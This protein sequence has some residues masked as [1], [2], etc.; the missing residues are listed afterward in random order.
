MFVPVLLLRHSPGYIRS[1][2]LFTHISYHSSAPRL[3]NMPMTASSWIPHCYPPTHRS[4]HID[5]YHSES[6]GEVKVP[7]PYAWLERDGEE[8]ERWLASQEALARKFLDSHPDRATLEEEIRSSTDYEKVRIFILWIQRNV[9]Y[10]CQSSSV[11]PHCGTM[12]D[13]T[14]HIIAAC[15]RNLV[16]HP[17]RGSILF[18][19][20]TETVY[21]R[22]KD[23][24][25]PEAVL[26]P[27][28]EVFFDVRSKALPKLYALHLVSA[29]CSV[30]RRLCFSEYIVL[31]A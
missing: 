4:D 20:F 13:G 31:L 15:S 28:G 12:V 27:G 25:L 16:C 9:T 3:R 23:S 5:V 24:K 6:Q 17:I 7:D 18:T 21:Y 30:K 19:K 10:T 8:R 26:G 22:S 1:T 14:G 11:H 2:S 29:Q